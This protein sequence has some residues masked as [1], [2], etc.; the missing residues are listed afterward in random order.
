MCAVG[1]SSCATRAKTSQE[2]PLAS[3]V[4][5]PP[6]PRLSIDAITSE[7]AGAQ[8]DADVEAW[9]DAMWRQIARNCRVFAKLGMPVTCPAPD[10][11]PNRP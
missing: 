11:D 4:V 6:K 2:F 9:G 1:A 7:T 5:P 10:A 8:H 3:E